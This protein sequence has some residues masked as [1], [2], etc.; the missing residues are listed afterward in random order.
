MGGRFFMLD[1]LLKRHN[2]I[3]DFG[4]VTAGV[5]NFCRIVFQD[6]NPV[7]YIGGMLVWV[8]RYA[9]FARRHHG[10]DFRPQ[11]FTRVSG[12][13]EFIHQRTV[14]AAFMP[15]PM[16]KFVQCGGVIPAVIVKLFF[17]RQVNFVGTGGVTGSIGIEMDNFRT[18]GGQQ[19]FSP[20]MVGKYRNRFFIV[21]RQ[22]V[23]LFGI[24][25]GE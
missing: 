16:A 23:Y 7:F 1:V 2:K 21:S 18:G 22:A 13:A 6:L 9:Q 25:Y 4:G 20:F 8:V 15:R 19:F 3:F 10:R 5:D 17:R 24:E 14:Q 11:L 12:C